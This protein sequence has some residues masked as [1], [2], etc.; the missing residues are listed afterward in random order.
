MINIYLFTGNK[1]HTKEQMAAARPFKAELQLHNR[2]HPQAA[3]C[4]FAEDIPAMKKRYLCS[5]RAHA[6]GLVSSACKRVGDLAGEACSLSFKRF[7]PLSLPCSPI[8]S[9]NQH[10]TTRHRSTRN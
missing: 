3:H 2:F 8:A 6:T 10:E 9:I 7:Q 5:S 1:T 4:V